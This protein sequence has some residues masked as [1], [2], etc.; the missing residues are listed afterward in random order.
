MWCR[1]SRCFEQLNLNLYSTFVGDL[2][3]TYKFDFDLH[4]GKGNK[5]YIQM[6]NAKLDFKAEKFH[7]D[8]TNLFNGDKTLGE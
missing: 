7:V 1:I 4:K 6:K 5:E 3:L 8:L 2:L